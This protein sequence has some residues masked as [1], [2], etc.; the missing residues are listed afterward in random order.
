MSLWPEVHT[1]RP[2]T[3]TT[4]LSMV[5]ALIT[6]AAIKVP[7]IS[8]R[9]AGAHCSVASRS[10]EGTGTPTISLLVLASKPSTRSNK[11]RLAPSLLYVIDSGLIRCFT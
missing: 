5:R 11:P 2:R 6:A 9:F 8:V 4:K 1:A 3:N 10:C 7:Q